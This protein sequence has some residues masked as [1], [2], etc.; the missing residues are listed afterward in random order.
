MTTTHPTL[1]QDF[2]H[3]AEIRFLDDMR[4]RTSMINPFDLHPEPPPKGVQE[5]TSVMHVAKPKLRLQQTLMTGLAN[6]LEDL[7]ARVHFNEAAFAKA[8]PHIFTA[9]QV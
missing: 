2:L 6:K 8:N 9:V 4:R 7:Q 1:L 5:S 3:I